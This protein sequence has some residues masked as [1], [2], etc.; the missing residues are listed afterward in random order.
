MG[1]LIHLLLVEN[2]EDDALLIMECLKDGGYEVLFERVETEESGID[3]SCIVLSGRIGEEPAVACI[4]QG[5]HGYVMKDKRSC[6]IPAIERELKEAEV[7]QG[8]R[9]AEEALK[10]TEE[11]FHC[12]LDHSPLG[13]RIVSEAGET[14]Y[15]NQT[16][17]DMYGYKGIEEFKKTSA[18]ERYTPESYAGY[19]LRRG[20]R[21][22]GEFVPS[23]YE[24]SIVRKGGEVL[25]LQVFRKESLWNGEPQFQVLY[26]DI[27]ERKIE[28]AAR[29]EG[30]QRLSDII[31][32]L[33]DATLAIDKDRRIIIW[34]RAIEEMTGIP[35]QEMIGK[36]D[37]AY[38]LPFYG[39]ARPQ[40]MDLFW[41]S[42]H[43]V[44]AKYPIL[45]REGYNL[46]IEVFCPALY[47]GK[48][49]FVWAKA[50]PLHDSE[51][52]LVGAIECIRDITEHKQAQQALQ[53]AFVKRQELEFIINHSSAIA[54][55]WKAAPG[56]PVEYVSDNLTCYGYTPDDFTSGRIAFASIVHPDDLPRVGAE[57][58]QYSYEGRSEFT[59]EY[60]IF[61]KS[62]E[63]RWIDSRTWVRRGPDGS[64]THYQGIIIDITER[65]RVEEKLLRSLESLRKAIGTTIQVM[66]AAVE[67][68]DP[69]TA[70]HQ[71]RSA[72]LARAI[73][74][75][76]GLPRER[77]EGI[78]IAG[79]IHDIGKMS[80]PAEILS[81]PIKLKALE[82]ALIKEHAGKGFEM[83]KD[84]E[85]PWPLAEIVYQHHERMD[86]S[87]YP[88]H[89][90]GEEILIEARILAVA[91]VVEAMASHRPYRPAIGLNAA[92][93]EIENNKGKLYDAD[94]VNACLKLFNEKGY[95]MLG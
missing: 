21:Q 77:I 54:W 31:E 2:R 39:V 89:L 64:V 22:R 91:D 78:R 16:L 19:L 28:E 32:F 9:Q 10:K 48:G 27:T 29:R 33:P 73:A 63:M 5:A 36:G 26:N 65:K 82:F 80:V 60:R 86:G 72:D 71:N 66:V 81:K 8:K 88:R 38:T 46:V 3:L 92:L 35:A 75:E 30:E 61:T 12:F 15:V 1:K 55:L 57:V 47:G 14:I 62:G 84:V 67:T 90:K 85:S 7:R 95:Q 45:Q 20:K 40:L 51:G 59:Q 4:K 74:T 11:N 50:S 24:I 52:R 49:A 76:M 58:E 43:E 79:S 87:G 56:W 53:A 69:Y 93:A 42:E 44:A 70:G 18:K 34:N 37:H 41:E 23:D 83:L 17:L 25:N 13:A 6:L 68:R 94:A